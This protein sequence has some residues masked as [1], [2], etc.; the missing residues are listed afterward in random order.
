MDVGPYGYDQ[1]AFT[2]RE[3]YLSGVLGHVL[4]ALNIGDWEKD[5]ELKGTPD[6]M[7][8]MLFREILSGY[9][10]PPPKL[11]TF[12]NKNGYD[13]MVVKADIETYSTCAHHF[14]TFYGKTHIGY[15]PS[16]K[17]LDPVLGISKLARVVEWYARRL[18]TQE[19]LTKQVGD[20][21]VKHVS[22]NV[23]V[24]TE[25]KHLCEMERGVEKQN[26]SLICASVHGKFRQDTAKQEFLRYVYR[27]G[28]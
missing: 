7:A 16:K 15:I 12:P 6:R 5:P 23:M 24:I 13:E 18:Q 14:L 19:R 2:D 10:T 28:H 3:V 4:S 26:A 27:N 11:T 9:Y 17:L 1:S 21:L 22:P 20:F 8:K 25:M